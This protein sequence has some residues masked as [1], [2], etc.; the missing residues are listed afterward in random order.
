MFSAETKATFPQYCPHTPLF[1]PQHC[2]HV[3]PQT[4]L[5]FHDIS[6]GVSTHAA[7]FP[8]HCPHTPL[9][10]VC[11]FV[12]KDRCISTGCPLLG[13]HTPACFH[14][15]VRRFVRTHLR[16]STALSANHGFVSTRSLQI[17]PPPPVL[18][19]DNVRRYVHKYRPLPLPMTANNSF[20]ASVCK[21]TAHVRNSV[22]TNTSTADALV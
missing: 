10:T 9:N 5:C 21:T 15:I 4:P 3:C 16:L 17:C 19:H 12:R 11:M 1:V 7:V 18:F 8:L 14:S 6:A 2:L 22:S 20:R 13:P